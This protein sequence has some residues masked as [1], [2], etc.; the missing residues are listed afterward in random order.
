M[1]RFKTKNNDNLFVGTLNGSGLAVGRTLIAIMEN[2]QQ[3]DGSIILTHMLNEKGRIQTEL[4]IT[5]FPNNVFYVLS[6][7][8]SEIRDFDWFNRH[9]NKEETVNIKNVTKDYGVLVLAGPKSR[10]VLSQLTSQSLNNND[11]PW[12]KGKEILINKIPVRALRVNYVGELGWELHHPMDHMESL[13][14]SIYEVGKKEN[15]I[16]FGTYAVNSLRMEK[17]YRGWGAELTGEISLVES[18]MDRFFNLKKKNNFFGAKAL[19]NKIQSGVDIKIVYL[20][21]DVGNADARGNEPVYHN[22]K[23]VG[24][25]TSGGYGFRTKKSLAFAYV[26]SDLANSGNLE[27]EIQG[28]RR[29]TKILDKVVYDPDNQKLRA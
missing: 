29:K 8:A 15:I 9:L 23:I 20:E 12:L 7:T 28:Q 24:V 22:N 5:R 1:A 19:Q 27:I 10:K 21:V 3:K 16:N 11:F 18:G 4:T 6:S 17:A 2:Y 14:D 26:K 25:V 13:Y